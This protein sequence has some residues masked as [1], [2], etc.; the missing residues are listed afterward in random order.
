[1]ITEKYYPGEPVN[2]Y[3]QPL[4]NIIDEKIGWFPQKE[5]RVNLHYS[6][7][8]ENSYFTSMQPTKTIC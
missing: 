1:M 4:I 8:T 3:I 6:V 5:V 7:V 2:I